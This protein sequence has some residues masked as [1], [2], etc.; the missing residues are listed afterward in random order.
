M[1]G[2]HPAAAGHG[3]STPALGCRIDLRHDHHDGNITAPPQQN[4]AGVGGEVQ[5]AFP[6]LALAVGYTPYGFL[7]SNFT[8]RGQWRPGNGPFTFSFVR[9]SV[10][11]TQLSYG[12][13]RD[14]GSASLSF[15]GTIW[16]G[17][18]A[19]QGNVQYCARR[20]QS[21]FYL[22]VGGQYLTGYQGAN[23]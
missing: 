6:H 23:E 7:V 8:A 12:G 15:P 9:D 20:C 4:A 21:G 2:D 13:L 11:D 1:P 22:G 16:G 18:M 10:K 19:N 14:P 17:V 5:L 3:R